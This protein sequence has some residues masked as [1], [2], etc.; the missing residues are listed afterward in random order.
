M[1]RAVPWLARVATKA[2][3]PALPAPE[4][5]MSCQALRESSAVTALSYACGAIRVL[6]EE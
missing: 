5:P 3:L 1:R 4:V 6:A 2:G